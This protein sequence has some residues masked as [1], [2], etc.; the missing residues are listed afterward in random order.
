[1][2]AINLMF[3]TLLQIRLPKL[4]FHSVNQQIV[5]HLMVI[6]R[7][8]TIQQIQKFLSSMVFVRNPF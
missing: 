7:N 6:D 8:T 3:H 5:K 2:Q 4:S 1:M